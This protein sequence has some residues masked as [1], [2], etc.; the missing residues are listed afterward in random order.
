MVTQELI[1]Y[2]RAEVNKGKTR[3]EISKS[4]LA[5]GGWNENDINEA[6]RDLVPVQPQIATPS[7]ATMA[8]LQPNLVLRSYATP[9]SN[10]GTKGL[11]SFLIF[12][13]IAMI[14]GGGGY[15]F[16]S[17]LKTG[18]QGFGSFFSNLNFSLPDMSSNDKNINIDNVAPLP[19]PPVTPAV[20]PVV[21]DPVI[22]ETPKIELVTDCGISQSPNGRSANSLNT[23]N[24]LK[25]M[26]EKILSCANAKLIINTDL[27][28]TI[29]ELVH[30]GSD[31]N[32][33]LAY[34]SNSKIVS[35]SGNRL[36]G[37][38]I[39]CPV[40]SIKSIDE[41]NPN[42]PILK[43]PHTTNPNLYASEAY[44]YGTIGV[45]LES[46]FNKAKINSIGC[47]GP[48]VDSVIDSFNQ[49]KTN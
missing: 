4:L 7:L 10:N 41:T 37:Q 15:F 44:V 24:A 27:F 19:L 5:G 40:S 29:F 23:D 43:S 49:S 11:K 3:E 2:V 34:E 28:P 17:Q 42:K 21:V 20:N 36:A 39:L 18:V 45:F 38:Y 1:S 26:G 9:K 47:T 13:I 25:C 31:C 6:F 22:P 14:L 30:S 8:P 12:L 32:L 46:N 16:R 35:V 33:K 48:Y